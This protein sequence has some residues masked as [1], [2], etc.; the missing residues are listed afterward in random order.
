MSWLKELK[1]GDKV[2][3][4]GVTNSAYLGTVNK[5]TPKGFIKVGRTLFNPETG[6]AKGWHPN[7][8]RL[9]SVNSVE[10]K[11]LAVIGKARS[12]RKKLDKLLKNRDVEGLAKLLRRYGVE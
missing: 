11:E 6:I 2:I 5:I 12:I 7:L 3:I 9:V 4:T 10:G 8:E 1:P